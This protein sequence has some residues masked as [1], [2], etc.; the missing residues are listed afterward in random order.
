MHFHL[1]R[2]I[3]LVTKTWRFETSQVTVT[4][5]ALLSQWHS[6]R[7]SKDQKYIQFLRRPFLYMETVSSLDDRHGISKHS[8]AGTKSNE[9]RRNWLKV[10]GINSTRINLFVCAKFLPNL[11]SDRLYVESRPTKL[12]MLEWTRRCWVHSSS[13]QQLSST[14]D[15]FRSFSSYLSFERCKTHFV[16]MGKNTPRIFCKYRKL[17][18]GVQMLHAIVWRF[19]FKQWNEHFYFTTGWNTCIGMPN[20][21]PLT[22]SDIK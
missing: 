21:T 14:S 12:K 17:R 3:C 10:A 11:I 7:W 19:F 16:S 15:D 22:S 1:R 13:F 6:V 20:H 4:S 2:A 8:R 9:S 18:W 5:C